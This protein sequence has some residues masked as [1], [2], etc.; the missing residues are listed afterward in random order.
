MSGTPLARRHLQRVTVMATAAILLAACGSDDEV[1]SGTDPGDDPN[2]VNVGFAGPLT[3]LK[4][5]VGERMLPGAQEAVEAIN[6]TGGAAGNQLNLVQGDTE[7][8]AQGATG[9][10]SKLLGAD[11]V[12]AIVG[13]TSV[14]VMSVLDRIQE[15]GV[16]T[17]VIGGTTALDDTL[18][19]E[20]TWRTAASDS[21]SGPAM[22]LAA[23]NAGHDNCALVFEDAEGAQSVKDTVAEALKALGGTVAADIGLAV[24]QS[25]YRSSLLELANSGADCAFF[26][27]SP[28]TA[29]AFWQNASQFDALSDIY[30]VGNDVLL[31]DAGI[32]AATPVLDQF[33]I[34]AVSPAAIG[35]GREDFVAL[36][37]GEPPA[38]ADLAYDAVNIL[39]LAA[40]A[41]QSWE[42][43]A[44]SAE[45]QNVS[46]D[47]E[48][49]TSF[50]DCK[51]LLEAGTDIDYEGASGSN[52]IDD[53]GNSASSFGFFTIEDGA[54]TQSGTIEESDVIEL[55][56][57]LG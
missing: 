29:A 19:G 25:D 54:A 22:A 52:N 45:V 26:E 51:T 27:L 14:T 12:A 42:K 33:Q 6:A 50:S 15:S 11:D 43:D 49:C 5:S 36:F 2:G 41:A 20:T 44:V 21:L 32:T 3:G 55:V 10:I 18:K 13:P 38:L 56:S 35:P 28:E 47:G 9:A 48:V 17:I 40:E 39:A 7:S 34:V 30:W 46:R 1:S 23:V 24:G 8:T 16:P 37:D 4:A 31:S 53:T 57:K